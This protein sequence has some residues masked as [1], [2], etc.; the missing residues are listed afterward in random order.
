MLFSCVVEEEVLE[1]N[2]GENMDLNMCKTLSS[3]TFFEESVPGPSS[4]IN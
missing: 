3:C 4:T 2:E 1:C